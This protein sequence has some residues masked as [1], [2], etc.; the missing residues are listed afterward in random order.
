MENL[1][2]PLEFIIDVRF[3]I[4]K[5]LS[6]K[7]AAELA[8]SKASCEAWRKTLCIWLNLLEIGRP[9]HPIKENLS[10]A[11]KQCLGLLEQGIAGES[12]YSHICALEEELLEAAHFEMEQYIAT[13]SIKSL[14]PLLFFQF[15]AFLILLL[16]PF[17][18]Q[19]LSQS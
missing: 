1:A 10:M 19:F 14:V 8:A 15:P 16:G 2:P 18:R 5:G 17:L 6:V 13:L 7:K 12:I 3:S 11:R 4:E 9:T